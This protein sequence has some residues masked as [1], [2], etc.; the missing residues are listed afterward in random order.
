M[1]IFITY[2]S[3]QVP[4]GIPGGNHGNGTSC[5]RLGRGYLLLM[6]WI[7]KKGDLSSGLRGKA[8]FIDTLL[9]NEM[10]PVTL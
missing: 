7:K 4:V 3:A 2:I 9:W 5:L 6:T 10:T 8:V 1:N